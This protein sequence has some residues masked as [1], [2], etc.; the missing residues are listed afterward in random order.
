MTITKHAALLLMALVGLTGLL[1][2]Q[3]S[4]R[5]TAQVPFDFVADYPQ[6]KQAGIDVQSRDADRVVMVPEQ[7][8]ALPLRQSVLSISRRLC[9]AAGHY[10]FGP[11]VAVGGRQPS[12][13][14]RHR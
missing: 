2:A 7:A 3:A 1:N 8:G 4:T 12:V 5:I 14:M 10:V 6:P 9:A 11:A 13:Q